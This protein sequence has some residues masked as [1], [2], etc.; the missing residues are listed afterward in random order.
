MYGKIVI[1][2]FSSLPRQQ[3]AVLTLHLQFSHAVCI[4]E[5]ELLW[6][7]FFVD[8]KPVF[9]QKRALVHQKLPDCTAIFCIAINPG[10]PFCL[11]RVGVLSMLLNLLDACILA[12]GNFDSV[13][14]NPQLY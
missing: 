8:T 2:L 9:V 7:L 6:K 10:D 13:C 11:D 12:F 5:Q 1:S 3:W 4:V 14:K